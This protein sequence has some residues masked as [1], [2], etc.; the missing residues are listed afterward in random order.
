MTRHR[1][2]APTSSN[3]AAR[4]HQAAKTTKSKAWSPLGNFSVRGADGE[5]VVRSVEVVGFTGIALFE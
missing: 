1:T 2:L 3:P 5:E 4:P